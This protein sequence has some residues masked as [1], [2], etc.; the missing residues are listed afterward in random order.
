MVVGFDKEDRG[1]GGFELKEEIGDG[2][3]WVMKLEKREVGG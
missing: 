3:W 2:I 1:G